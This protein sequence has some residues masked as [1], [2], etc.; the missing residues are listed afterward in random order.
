ME[1]EPIALLSEAL[2][3]ASEQAILVLDIKMEGIAPLVARVIRESGRSEML[4][5]QCDLLEAA[6]YRELLPEIPIAS[7][8]RA[9]DIK[10]DGYL[11]LLDRCADV[12]LSGVSVRNT[13]L[14]GCAVSEAHRRGLMIKTWTVDRTPDIERVLAAGVDAVCGNYPALMRAAR[15]RSLAEHPLDGDER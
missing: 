13:V 4:H 3:A 7:G 10:R 1:S 2:A 11:V 12:G 6:E 15:E 5:L 9:G 8:L 14:D